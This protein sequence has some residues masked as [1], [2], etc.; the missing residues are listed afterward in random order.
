VE[1]IKEEEGEE[2]EDSEEVMR[3]EVREEEEE[4]EELR[5]SARGALSSTPHR[6]TRARCANINCRGEHFIHCTVYIQYTHIPVHQA[7]LVGEEPAQF[8]EQPRSLWNPQ[9][10]TQRLHSTTRRVDSSKC[11]PRA[12]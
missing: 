6:R 5:S 3:R 4:E 7:C 12:G 2:E 11:Q 1:P 9:T 10:L 8:K